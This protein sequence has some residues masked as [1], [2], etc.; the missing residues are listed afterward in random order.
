MLCV[1]RVNAKITLALSRPGLVNIRLRGQSLPLRAITGANRI[2]KVT[3]SGFSV[4]LSVTVFGLT[5][6][7]QGPLQ[8]W[9]RRSQKKWCR[10]ESHGAGCHPDHRPQQR[11]LLSLLSHGY[12]SQHA[13]RHCRLPMQL[14]KA[15]I[16]TQVPLTLPRLVT[17]SCP[18]CDLLVTSIPSESLHSSDLLKEARSFASTFSRRPANPNANICS[19]GCC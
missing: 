16:L 18:A 6:V 8:E 13:W 12:C 9:R 14:S 5:F 19:L 17:T 10:Q 2:R 7:E 15:K 1:E 11:F 3:I 4:T